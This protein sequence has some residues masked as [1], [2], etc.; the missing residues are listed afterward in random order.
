[1]TA[2]NLAG[3]GSVTFALQRLVDGGFWSTTSEASLE[4]TSG[5]TLRASLPTVADVP[6]GQSVQYR[7][8]VLVDGVEMDRHTVDSLMVKEETARD[9]DALSQQVSDDIFSITLFLIALISVSFGL[10]AMVMRRRFLNP[11]EE[12]EA[13]QT[14][15]VDEEMKQNTK[16]VPDLTEAPAPTSPQPNMTA[17]PGLDR[18]VPPPV[19]P[20]GLPNG[21]TTEQWDSYGWQYIDALTK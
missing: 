16:L 15:V 18:T 6:A 1:V 12:D 7:V 19:P 14:N 5:R 9:G 3:D 11:E 4:A 2:D 20:T 21:W 13:D 10:W 8:L 17:L